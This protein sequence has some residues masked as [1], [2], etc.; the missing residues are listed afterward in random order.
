MSYFVPP[1]N[2][3]MVEYDL[4]RSGQCHQLNFPFLERLNLRTVIYLSH[5]E[6][7]QPFLS[8]LEDQGIALIRPKGLD[9]DIPESSPMSEAEVLFALKV[10]FSL[11]LVHIIHCSR[12]LNYK[13]I[14]EL[15]E[16]KRVGSSIK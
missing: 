15:N 12:Q 16:R 1:C 4:S 7:S 5:D 9:A 10:Y 14:T 13:S 8:F 11:L 3:G 6:P 2:Y